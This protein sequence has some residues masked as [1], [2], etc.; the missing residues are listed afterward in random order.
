M[1]VDGYRLRDCV[2]CHRD[3]ICFALEPTLTKMI[4]RELHD[5]L[6]TRQTE[7]IYEHEVQWM[8]DFV[9]RRVSRL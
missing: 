6:S 1:R 5:A 8:V 9:Y 7:A 4:A 3:I 2:V